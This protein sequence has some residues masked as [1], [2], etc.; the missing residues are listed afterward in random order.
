M[1]ISSFIG[2]GRPQV[3]LC[4]LF[5]AQPLGR[6]VVP[7]MKESKVFGGIRTYS[8]EGQVTSKPRMPRIE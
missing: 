2:G 7:H 8:N 4:A 3:S 1:A 6:W 5:L